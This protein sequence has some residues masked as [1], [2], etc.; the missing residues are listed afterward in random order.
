MYRGTGAG[1]EPVPPAQ[2]AMAL[3]VQSY[4]ALSDA[5]AVEASV[6]DLRWQLLL[7]CLGTTEPPFQQGAL[8]AFRER[9][10]AHDMDRRLLE[11]TVELAKSTKEFDWKK[12][13]KTL[14]VAIDHSAPLEGAGRVEDTIN[15]VAHAARKVVECAAR[16]SACARRRARPAPHAE[17]QGGTRPRLERP[18]P[19]GRRGEEPRDR[20]SHETSLTFFGGRSS[21]ES[22]RA[23]GNSRAPPLHASAQPARRE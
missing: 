21:A 1:S 9:L 14:R 22:S 12:L 5:D 15:L 17:H 3:I 19:E 18:G 8:Q 4:L 16:W 10:I 2:L 11:R 20:D 13:P 6:L 7:G 23:C